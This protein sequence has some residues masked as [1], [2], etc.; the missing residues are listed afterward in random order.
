MNKDFF[1]QVRILDSGMGQELL[2]RNPSHIRAFS[3]LK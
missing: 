2:A 3:E 1:K